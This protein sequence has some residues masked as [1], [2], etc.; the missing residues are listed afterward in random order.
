MKHSTDNIEKFLAHGWPGKPNVSDQALALLIAHTESGKLTYNGCSCLIG[1]PGASH[2]PLGA[3]EY[4]DGEPDHLIAS[5]KLP[6][7]LEAEHE[8]CMLGNDPAR[9]E[10]VLPLLYAE[11]DRRDAIDQMESSDSETG[12]ELGASMAR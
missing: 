6:Y 9:R 12:R 3:W 8:F 4:C 7:A 10:H 5:R 11:R 2:P 1:I